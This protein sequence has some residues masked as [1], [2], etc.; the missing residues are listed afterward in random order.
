MNEQRR[1]FIKSTLAAAAVSAWSGSGAAQAQSAASIEAGDRVFITNEDS[2]TIVV[3]DPRSNVVET[4]I[5]LTSFDE[6]PRP[7]FRFG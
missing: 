4:T 3:I 7:P 1:S 2:N 6:D 5:N